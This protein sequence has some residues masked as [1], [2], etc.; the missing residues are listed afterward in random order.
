MNAIRSLA[1][2]ALC[3]L[4]A[5]PALAQSPAE[6]LRALGEELVQG[7]FDLSP[8]LEAFSE[9][10]GPRAA[11]TVA[12]LTPD[13]QQR[14]RA[15]YARVLDRLQAIPATD[16]PE[17]ERL[18]RALI[19]GHAEA[20]LERHRYPLRA[21]G[22]ATPIRNV[23]GLLVAV[24][25]SAQ[26]LATE[27]DFV[28]WLARVEASA[29]AFHQAIAQLDEAA[30]EG[31]TAPRSLVDSTLR[32]VEPMVAKGARDGPFW[33]MLARY[34][35]EAGAEKRAAFEQRYATA[36]EG[37]LLPAMRRFAAYLR[38][39]YRP[40]ARTTS[41]LG[42]LPG[43]DR[44]YRALIRLHTTLELS[45]AEVHALGLAEVARVR[46]KLLD[47]ARGLGFKGE[48]REF[49]A[50]VAANPANYPFKSP[51]DVLAY[52]RS[53]HAR[54]EPALPK[55]FHRLPRAGFEIR[56]TPAA[57][58]A[59]ASATYS[60]PSADGKRPGVF[61]IPV[62][63]AKRVAAFP[64]T[65]L[66]MHEG[67]PGH[68]LDI[69]RM[70]ELDLPRFRKVASLTVYSEGWGLYAEGL[71]QE[72][73]AYADP[74]ALLGRHS[75]ELHRA[76]RLVV[77]TGLHWKGWSREQAIRYLVEE[78]G[79]TEAGATVAVERYMSDP[80]QA[81]AYKI[82]ELEILKLREEAKSTLGERFDLRDF[83]EAVLG[84][85][86][87]TVGLLRERVRGWIARTAAQAGG[88][89]AAARDGQRDFDFSIGT[90]TTH[91]KR[92][93]RPLT[94]SDEW[95]EYDGTSTV[96]EVLGGRANLVELRVA[97][98]AG[99]IE[100]VSLRLYDPESRRWSLNYAG[101]SSGALGPP[102][103]G[104]FTN[105]RGE[106]LGDETL[107]AKPIR[108]RFVISGVGAD[109]ARYEQA[110]SADGGKTWEVN[111]IATDTRLKD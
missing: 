63:D 75:A 33:G 53:A 107:G 89:P 88:A 49:A 55:V 81:L 93:V 57:I 25:A 7:E 109:S 95:V 78:R 66:L 70:V 4:L 39:I 51:E 43:G 103:I 27:A 97:G 59:S 100:G 23:A 77:D 76:A 108:V 5:L 16:L 41:G 26:P 10:G 1:S 8:A 37:Q 32:Q 9:G 15:L 73:G 20:Q 31:W 40:K 24:G 101:A 104:T 18:N 60:R 17:A 38:D 21:I 11:R 71:G 61:H 34:P 92:R 48:M 87:L 28:A 68:H 12:D 2:A 62:T 65:S 82:G 80:G 106:F 58:A 99:R 29:T 74:W 90:W 110:F 50:W 42:A 86:Q 64:L 96:R 14:Y 102:T 3:C 67:M 54:I 105:G 45:P 35:K 19:E 91:V 44:A 47:V 79:Q 56:L 111:W 13:S 83:H 6:R 46:T 36:V 22:L 69:A 72:L 98:P 52:L 94:G 84:G 85:G 30:R